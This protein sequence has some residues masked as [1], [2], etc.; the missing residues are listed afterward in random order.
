MLKPAQRQETQ[1]HQLI[2]T[3]HQENKGLRK[4]LNTLQNK[5]SLA[6]ITL[7]GVSATAT[8]LYLYKNPTALSDLSIAISANVSDA[9]TWAASFF[10][11]PPTGS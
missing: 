6:T 4:Q 10:K 1:N 7:L 9:Y 8:A 3:L 11:T 2:Q 5:V